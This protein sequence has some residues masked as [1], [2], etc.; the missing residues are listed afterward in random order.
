LLPQ[1]AYLGHAALNIYEETGIAP[2]MIIPTGNLGHAFAAIYAR[3]MGLPIGPIIA[4]TNANRTLRDWAEKGI[5][6][7]RPAVATIA[8]AMD[9]GAPSNFERLAALH[10]AQAAIHVELV[11]DGAI[12]ERIRA[13][14]DASSYVWC[15]HSATAAEAYARLPAEQKAER[16]WIAAAHGRPLQVR[17]PGRAADRPFD[18][19]CAPAR[20]DPGARGEDGSNSRDGRS[21]GRSASRRREVDAAGDGAADL[22]KN[23][24]VLAIISVAAEFT[25]IAIETRRAFGP[26]IHISGR[27]HRAQDIVPIATGGIAT[28]GRGTDMSCREPAPQAQTGHTVHSRVVSDKRGRSR[29]KSVR[30]RIGAGAQRSEVP[31]SKPAAMPQNIMRIAA[32]KTTAFATLIAVLAAPACLHAA[33][34]E[35][36]RLV[37]TF[38]PGAETGAVMVSLFDTEAAYA[39]GAPVRRARVDISNGGRTAVFGDLK[40]GV[41]AIKAFHDVNGDGKMK[42]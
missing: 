4:V 3:A 12:R 15:P 6:E 19:A 38:D 40:V 34:G 35:A 10:P 32:M 17:R 30:R 11:G 20:C 21:V 33:T 25:R 39:G 29:M 14:Y 2:G 31:K 5:Y 24:I 18:R 23:C 37:L 16:V 13:E 42:H 8:N 26:R 41:Y 9:V 7:P 28:R 27:Q 1:M 22:A 36:P